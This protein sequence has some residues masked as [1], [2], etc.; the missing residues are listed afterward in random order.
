MT[1]DRMKDKAEGEF[2]IVKGLEYIRGIS[3]GSSVM[4]L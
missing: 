2:G 4:R 1:L 3:R